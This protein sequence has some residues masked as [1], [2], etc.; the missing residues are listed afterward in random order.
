MTR[1]FFFGESARQLYGVYH[2]PRVKAV[3]PSSVLLCPPFGQEYM[4]THWAM[5]Q[6]AAQ[7]A[8]AGAHVL[9][10]DY[11]GTGDSAGWAEDA[12]VRDRVENI[13]TAIDELKDTAG[14]RRVSV[15]G[16]RL[17]AFLAGWA[18]AGRTDLVDCVFWDPVVSGRQYVQELRTMH[19]RLHP[20][21]HGDTSGLL[22]I[23]GFP[24]TPAFQQELAGYDLR[25]ITA[26][27]ARRLFLV[28]SEP[29]IEYRALQVAWTGAA[30]PLRSEFI[31]SPARWD[32]VDRLGAV[33]LPQTVI[34]S[35]VGIL[36]AEAA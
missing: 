14:T 27:T 11:Y 18:M 33:L 34:Q 21:R 8:R 12:T 20:E 31:D 15:V 29:R 22:G 7:L 4:R 24:L 16:L 5:R 32:D 1:S 26:V 6:L 13:G 28:A 23:E 2:A 17:G 25:E 35:V 10:F 3:Q 19:D 36:Q 30:L 9:R